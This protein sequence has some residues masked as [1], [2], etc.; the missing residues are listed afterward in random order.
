LAK[1]PANFSVTVKVVAIQ[2]LSQALPKYLGTA[3]FTVIASDK[4]RQVTI[5]LQDQTVLFALPLEAAP[6]PI[7]ESPIKKFGR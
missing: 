3:K 4:Y 5:T 2:S 6:D 1:P 7:C